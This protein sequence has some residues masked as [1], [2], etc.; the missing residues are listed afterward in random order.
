[1]NWL[2]KC[3]TGVLVLVIPSLPI[4]ELKKTSSHGQHCE[5]EHIHLEIRKPSPPLSPV[6]GIV[7]SGPGTAPIFPPFGWERAADRAVHA[8]YAYLRGRT[9]FADSFFSPPLV[10]AP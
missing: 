6:A 7:G 10:L 9:H 8:R 1:M 4:R 5:H 3:I 2:R